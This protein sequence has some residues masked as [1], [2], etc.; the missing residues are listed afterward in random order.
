MRREKRFVTSHPPFPIIS[1][2]A[3]VNSVTKCSGNSNK[4]FTF[5][6]GCGKA[7]SY[8]HKFQT[9]HES[10]EAVVYTFMNVQGICLATLHVL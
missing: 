2:H 9:L 5:N 3:V 1:T 8:T 4:M 10:P 6:C 7:T